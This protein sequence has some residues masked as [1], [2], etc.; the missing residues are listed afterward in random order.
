MCHDQASHRYAELSWQHHENFVDAC[1]STC[2]QEDSL[3][4][5]YHSTRMQ[6]FGAEQKRRILM[7]T[8]A[9]SAGYIDAYYTRAQQVGLPGV[10]TAGLGTC[11]FE[12]GMPLCMLLQLRPDSCIC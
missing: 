12:L 10:V 6:G 8:Y 5:M 1:L 9:L 2:L 3:R 7:G 4:K 11:A